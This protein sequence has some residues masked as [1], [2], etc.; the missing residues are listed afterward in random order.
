LA[1]ELAKDVIPE[2]DACGCLLLLV[3]IGT[4][5]TGE[6]FAKLTGVQYT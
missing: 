3:S 6:K 5:E 1:R 4:V 2:L